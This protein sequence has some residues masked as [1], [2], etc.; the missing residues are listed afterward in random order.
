MWVI[1]SK[2]EIDQPCKIGE[3]LYIKSCAYRECV[4]EKWRWDINCNRDC[5]NFWWINIINT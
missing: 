3:Y 2:K 5:I 1:Q 4:I